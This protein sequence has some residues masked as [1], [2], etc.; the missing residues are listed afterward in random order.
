VRLMNQGATVID[1]RPAE[2]FA[3]GTCAV[4]ATCPWK[5]W[6]TPR[7]LQ[8]PEGKA[9]IVCCDRGFSRRRRSVSSPGRGLQGRDLRGG[10]RP[11]VRRICLWFATKAM[12]APRILIYSKGW[13]PYCQRARALLQRKGAASRKSDIDPERRAE[14]IERSGRRTVC[15]SSSMHTTLADPMSCMRWKPLAG[16]MRCV[17]TGVPA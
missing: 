1:L 17:G 10:P 15:R 7:N 11:G 2:A 8:A 16:S 6:V 14:M 13:C 4:R 12:S 5:S 3:A 9:I